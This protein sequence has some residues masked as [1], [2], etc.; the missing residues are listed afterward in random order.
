MI[1]AASRLAPR[2]L[3][4]FAIGLVSLCAAAQE[5]A[6]APLPTLAEL[7]AAGAIIGAISI[8]ARDIFATEDPQEDKL[9]FRWANKLHIQTQEGVV[10]R[11]LLFS[12]GEPVSVRLIDE[13]ERVLR[14][15]RYLREVVI[16]P[17]ALRE[18]VVDIEVQTRD[19]WTLDPGLSAGRSGGANSSGI[20]LREYNF[21]GSGVSLG[22][23]RSRNVDRSG[24]E[25]QVVNERAF[26]GWTSIAYTLARNSD[27][28][29]EA[30]SLAH[31]FYALDTPWAA[32]LSVAR[33]NR[34]DSVYNA[35]VLASQYR[36][37]QGQLDAYGGWSSGRIDGWVNRYSIG[38]LRTDDRYAVEPGLAAPPM[39]PPDERLSGPY[40][41]HELIEDR[42]ERLENRSQIGRP[43]FFALGFASSVELGRSSTALGANANA[44]WYSA[45]VNR[46]FEPAPG[47]TVLASSAIS[48]RRHED[49]M[50]RQRLGA[51]AQYFAPQSPA[52]LF[53]ASLAGDT[54]NKPDAADTLQLGGDSGL[55][56]YPLRYQS[57]E[58]RVLATLEQRYYTDLYLWRLLRF[59][60][61]AFF[62]TG[63]AWSGVNGNVA[64]PGWL[65][66][67]GI[68]LRIFS[69]RAAFSNVLHVDVAFP[70]DPDSQVKRVQ[71][72]IKTK[73]SF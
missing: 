11:A 67:A 68:G 16:R 6:P 23:V 71:F 5:P 58:R 13:T 22:V 40:L 4:W 2:R 32:G 8:Q 61:A 54:L 55:R 59:G 25:Y 65:S 38:L 70:L 29:R 56:G 73:S 7:E 15:T 35:G 24:T 60:G 20:H 10:R 36:H 69:T 62:D 34:I 49:G 30:A 63:R 27:G 33:D 72:G 18:G 3:L 31:P 45:K 42:Y 51:Q 53:Y 48:G 9:L 57:G 43:E 66:S 44:W 52:W 12:S 47:H 19:T 41:R 21:L 28:R 37:R 14:S 17:I 26:G 64:N 50:R 46:G 39:L 1:D